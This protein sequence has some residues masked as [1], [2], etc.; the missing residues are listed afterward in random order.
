MPTLLYTLLQ[1]YN[2][3]IR[4]ANCMDVQQKFLFQNLLSKKGFRSGKMVSAGWQSA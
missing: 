4:N 1:N 2:F 3:F